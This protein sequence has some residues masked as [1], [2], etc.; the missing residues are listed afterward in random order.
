MPAVTRTC[1]GSAS[2]GRRAAGVRRIVR[3]GRNVP[4]ARD[5]QRHGADRRAP[6]VRSAHRGPRRRSSAVLLAEVALLAAVVLLAACGQ[7]PPAW[8]ALEPGLD[9]AEF[10]VD[11]GATLRALR[12]D[13]ARFE[14]RLLMASETPPARTVRDWC[15]RAG[16]LAGINAGMFQQDGLTSTS[17]L[18]S[19][20]H[21][22]NRRLTTHRS[23]LA[24]D[25]VDAGVPPVQIIDRDSQSFEELA[26]RYNALLQGIRMIS[27]DGRNVW[28]AQDER[29]SIAAVAIDRDGNVLLLHSAE[30]LAVHD[31]AEN[32]R[33]LPLG[34]RNAMY[35]EGGSTAQFFLSAGG[36]LVDRTGRHEGLFATD[37][38]VA[39]PVPN[40]LGVARRPRT[41]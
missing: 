25:P 23:V 15:T 35:L 28:A 11:G 20:T 1:S 29:F 9:L 19:K 36:T 5:L 17:L 7:R 6:Q 33:L 10:E 22:N 31:F 16:M 32:L 26:P 2:T 12:I 13:P 8:K 3:G 37:D 24:F 14:L 40:V 38:P 4:P 27:L 39:T 21:T 34:V 18:K 30:P 41:R